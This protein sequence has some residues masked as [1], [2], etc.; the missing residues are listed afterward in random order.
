MS[1]IVLEGCRAEPLGSYLKALGVLRLV[2]EQLDDQA[3]GG[4]FGERF[5]LES[6]ADEDELVDFFASRYRPTPLLSPWNGGSGFGEKDKASAATVAAIEAST[7]ERLRPYRDAV[8]VVRRLVA[9]PTWATASNKKGL[10]KEQVARCRNE[11]PDDS[12]AWIDATVVLTT[13]SPTFA[14]L[15]GTGGNDHRLEFS[16]NFMANV[17]ASTGL[18][19]QR[20]GVDRVRLLRSSLF[21]GDPGPLP[22]G[23]SGPY[24]PGAGGGVNSAPAGEASA[25]V[26]PWDYV[27]M[28]EGG[29][30]FASGAAR[31]L[32]SDLGRVA[33][34]FC[35]DVSRVGRVVLG[36]GEDVSTEVWAPIWRRPA[37]APE[38]AR[39][40]GEGRAEWGRRPARNGVDFARAAATLGVDRGIAS[41]VRHG[42][43]KRFGRSYLAI[44][45][46]RVE[47]GRQPKVTVTTQVDGWLGRLKRKNAP[48]ALDG[49]LRRVEDA[50]YR[51]ATSMGPLS[52]ALQDVL[53]ELAR[54]EQAIARGS[55]PSERARRPIEKL[56]AP[57]WLPLLDDGTPELRLAAAIASGRDRDGKS[58]A[59]LLRPVRL[60]R[61]GQKLEWRDGPPVIDGIGR[62]PVTSVLASALARR[63]VEPTDT[64]RGPGELHLGFDFGRLALLDDVA[65]LVEGR[66][67][68]G[69]LGRL[70]QGLFLLE[71]RHDDAKASPI[72]SGVRGRG[73]V[74]PV[75][76]ILGPCLS[77]LTINRTGRDGLA[78]EVRLG[79]EQS[80]P[81]LLAYGHV[82]EVTTLALR[83]LR[84]AGLDP[85]PRYVVAQAEVGERLAAAAF[86]RLRAA[87]V[88]ALLDQCCP[89]P[90]EER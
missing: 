87:D 62:R 22:E 8:F 36:E 82:Q 7:D 84:M 72:S 16:A 81:T 20:K 66:L 41:F 74:P 43:V 5:V 31:R 13:E 2:G 71:W 26:N 75:L 33:V 32:G 25:M 67:D 57:D 4:W 59:L 21:D 10:K 1:R 48:G 77:G 18:E 3:T 79:I 51:A 44:A 30:L 83:R 89:R 12:I 15:F 29:L 28:F 9:S 17:L 49:A 11:L 38:V 90:Q 39:F 88:H 61:S 19:T 50:L 6:A 60:D 55:E 23:S 76:A 47:V 68:E 63:A 35:V 53:F 73:L 80:W 45:L 65:A 64:D 27:L 46:D 34:P 54:V 37:T 24:D 56:R 85:A 86:C 52:G 42:L 70:L 14:P 69:R 78:V 58:L 40:I